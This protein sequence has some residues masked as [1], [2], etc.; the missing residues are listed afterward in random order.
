MTEFV[1]APG[2]PE[3]ATITT[4][5]IVSFNAVKTHTGMG[6]LRATLATSKDLTEY[7]QRK[8]RINVN[9]NGSTEFT[10]IFV[11][12]GKEDSTGRTRIKAFGIAK[13]LQ[14]GRPD[15]ENLSNNELNYSSIALQ[16]AIDD[17]WTRTPFTAS[18][19]DQ[20]TEVVESGADIQSADTQTEWNN[21]VSPS[22]TEPLFVE[23]GFLKL[24][25]MGYFAEAESVSGAGGNVSDSP[26]SND[27]VK[28]FF[29]STH[30][31]T[32]S[33]TVDY[34]IPSENVA[35]GFRARNPEDPDDDG[36]FE[37][38]IID[39]TIAGDDLGPVRGDEPNDNYSWQQETGYS[40][41]D[42]SGS[43]DV[44]F[45]VSS[46]APSGASTYIDAVFLYD[47]RF[48]YTFDNTTDSNGYLSGPELYPTTQSIQTSDASTQFNIQSLTISSTWNDTSNGQAIG[49]SNDGGANF[50]T[51]NNTENATVN[52]PDGGR[53][54][55]IKFT[56]DGFGS[57]TT[58]TPTERFDGQ[59]ID[60]YDL[61]GDLDDLVVIDELTL[62]NNHFG[63]LQQ[64]HQYGNFLWV[65]EHDSS[66]VSNLTVT[67]FQEGD[68]TRST[69]SAYDDPID[70]TSS[71]DATNYY[72][73]LFLRGAQQ[74]DG[75]YPTSVVEDTDEIND[76][77]ETIEA[78]VKDPKI[79]TDAGADFRAN[80]LLDELTDENDRKGEITI[81]LLAS[82]THPGYARTIDFGD[83]G[84]LKTIEE[85]SLQRSQNQVSQTHKFEPPDN[86][87][88][89]LERLKRRARDI[90]D[91]V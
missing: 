72:N 83:G 80:A 43:I 75:S 20:S 71:V 34:T 49:L 4:D 10:G 57:R 86:V 64:L 67:S 37:G 18:V 12:P 9:I 62:T 26:A 61:D 56:L 22:S 82:V 17:Y 38:A 85:V 68:E 88:N 89:E 5:E 74:S 81:P 24:G 27:E 55:K 16:D 39:L 32:Y 36:T 13:K 31:A 53:T 65:I 33:F 23:N 78:T 45:D 63:N 29:D 30:S 66:D 76:V 7:A 19:T 11:K 73:K 15:Y 87:A 8:D 46:A 44:T 40:G 50:T 48:S 2:E 60:L 69:P 54:A 6:T 14:Q 77:G 79:T 59:E 91:Q 58:A 1:L 21:V 84:K 70:K 28:T 51:N 42:I 41:G 47:D 35:V 90:G 25:Q 3:E 52:F